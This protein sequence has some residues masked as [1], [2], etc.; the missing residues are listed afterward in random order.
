MSFCFREFTVED[1]KSSMRVGTDSMLLGSW[2]DPAGAKKILDIGTG[3]GVLALMMAQK[4]TEAPIDAVEI[5]QSSFLEAR[6]N[7]LNSP[8]SAR[9]SAIHDSIQTFSGQDNSFAYDFIISNPPYYARSLKSPNVRVNQTRHDESLTRTALVAV[10]NRLL[11]T[12]GRFTLILPS[13]AAIEFQD[14]CAG[15]GLYPSRR[16]VVYSKP[17]AAPSRTLTEFTKKQIDYPVSSG[18]T[19]FNVDGKFTSE[20]LAM[21]RDFHNF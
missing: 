9:I 13:E 10:V 6:N 15:S 8:W 12:D 5:D 14:I 7:F 4:N 11:T 21:T 20:Y 18:L 19:I 16:L 17:A 1:E 2:A 3:C